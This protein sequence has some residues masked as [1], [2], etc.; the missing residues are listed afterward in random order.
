MKKQEEHIRTGPGKTLK[1]LYLFIEKKWQERELK[2]P[3]T[4]KE[5]LEDF[6]ETEKF[7]KRIQAI[8]RKSGPLYF[9]SLFKNKN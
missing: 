3:F 2:I 4:Y 6:K 5:F 9:P 8:Q 7:N 1:S